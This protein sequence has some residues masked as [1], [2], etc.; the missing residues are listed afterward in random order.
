[1]IEIL[2]ILEFLKA[3]IVSSNYILNTDQI[4]KYIK[5]ENFIFDKER[6]TAQ[7]ILIKDLNGDLIFQ[8][9]SEEIRPIA[10]ISKLLT[11][12]V[13]YKIY[14]ED[15]IFYVTDEI[16]KI[17]GEQGKFS[18]GESFKRDDLLKM[19]LINS[20]NKAA[21]ILAEKIGIKN[22]VGLMNEE[23]K[24]LGMV[25]SKFVDPAGILPENVS[26]LNDIYILTTYMFKNYPQ[27]LKYS[28]IQSFKINNK[29]F[30][31]INYLLPYYKKYILGSKTGFTQ[32]AG[33]C[34]VMII[35]P[36][37]LHILFLGILNSK[38]RF[39]DSEYLLNRLIKFYAK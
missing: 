34:L 8:K 3:L 11:A 1:M 20:S 4:P 18:K 12:L 33:E 31:N 28:I 17:D 10:S 6:V 7:N 19:M 37:D 16:L 15:D 14:E 30:Y 39:K 9:N 38:N 13:S 36:D 26:T 27:I 21:Y 25:N 24:N 5:I 23:A 29:N 22:F 32:D 35:K 2:A